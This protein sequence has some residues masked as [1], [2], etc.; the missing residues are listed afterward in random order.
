MYNK[1]MTQILVF[2]AELL[3]YLAI[4]ECVTWG[5]II[6]VKLFIS[7][8]IQ[9]TIINFLSPYFFLLLLRLTFSF[10]SKNG[11]KIF[12]ILNLIVGMKQ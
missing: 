10:P 4:G 3:I 5:T 7:N 1:L 6:K 2:R 9:P 12:I 11:I 8:A